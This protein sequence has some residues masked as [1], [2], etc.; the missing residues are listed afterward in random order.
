M[1]RFVP[2]QRK[3]KVLARQQAQAGP[4]LANAPPPQSNQEII[5][6][7]SKAERE[8]KKQKLREELRA[9]QP[10]ISSKKQKR[11]DK[12]IE[13][14]LRKDETLDLLRKLEQ[15]KEKYEAVV[16]KSSGNLG[17]RTFGDFLSDTGPKS[18]RQTQKIPQVQDDS[19]LDSEASFETEHKEAFDEEKRLEEP[20]IPHGPQRAQG[21]GLA[22]PLALDENGLPIIQSRRSNKRIRPR[23]EVLL[24]LP[25]E[26]FDS[27]PSINEQDSEGGDSDNEE[28]GSSSGTPNSSSDSEDASDGEDDTDTS[29]A[30]EEDDGDKIKPRNSAFKAW[31]TQQLNRS[32]GH[33][34]SY[35]PGEGQLLPVP[36]PATKSEAQSREPPAATLV[37]NPVPNRKAYAVHVSRPEDIQQARS[38]LP[39]LQ[40]EQEIMEAIHNNPVV[41]IKGDTGSGKTT[42]IPQF[43]F[44]AGY[45]SPD[46][47]TPGMIGITQPRRVAAVSMAKRVS[48]ELGEH[49]HKVAYQIRFDS[50]VS[51]N[52]AVKFMTD[53]IL[54]R[55]LS[56][57]LLL[58]KYSAIVVDEAH[59][60]S[61]NTDIL[62]GMLS[63]I[64]PAR[65]QKNQFNP[66]PTPLKLVIM[67][68]TLN[69]GDFL[70]EKL[71]SASLRPPIVEAEGRQHRVTTHF[72]LR[73]RAD[74]VEEVIEKVRRAHRKLPRGS[75]LV[76][77][78]GQNEIKQVGNRLNA[79][80]ARGNDSRGRTNAP[81]VEIAAC[82]A[83]LEVEDFELSAVKVDDEQDDFEMEILTHSEDEAEEKEFDISDDEDQEEDETTASQIRVHSKPMDPY[84]SVHILPLYSQL[85]TAE[86]LKVFEPPPPGARLIVLATNV[87]ETSLTIPGI[88][89]VFDTGRS[90][91]RKYNLD[92]GVQSFEIDYISKASAQ[93]RAGRAGRTGPGHCWR[94]YSSAVYEQFFPDHAEPEILRAPAESVVLQLKGFA[95][96]RPIAEFPFPTPPAAQTLNKAEQL[97]R[98]LGA[99]TSSGSITDLGRQLSMY[100]LSPRLGKILAASVA[101]PD[102][103]WQILALVSALAVPEIFVTE[104]QLNLNDDKT[105][106]AVRQQDNEDEEGEKGVYTIEKQQEDDRREK[107]RQEYGRARATLSKND[108][109]SDAMKLL[110]AVSLYLDSSSP[111]SREALCKSLFLRP[112]AMA[113]IAQ[114][115]DQLDHLV[116]MNHRNTITTETISKARKTTKVS[117]LSKVATKINTIVASG[118]IDQIAIRYDK[119]P[120][121]PS[122]IPIKPRR[123]IDV[124]YLPLVPLHESP[125]APLN[126]KAVFIHPSSVLARANIKDLP[127]Y[128]CYSHLQRSQTHTITSASSSSHAIPKTR[129]FPLTPVTAAQ[130]AY[131]A[132]DTALV[133]YGKPVPKTKI[134]EMPGSPRRRECW[135]TV[136]L[137]AS[138]GGALGWPLPPAKV[139]QVMDVKSKTGWR[140]EKVLT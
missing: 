115:R 1:P 139:R 75:I 29:E 97:L 78:T 83:P 50:N 27:E 84:T 48:T 9:Q 101:E 11:L 108:K 12:Y 110:T 28:E 72:A 2:R 117:S 14:K 66:N 6:P 8:A 112:K 7:Q 26:G 42:Q 130:L 79:L 60:R 20:P 24:E 37:P 98:N 31:A 13:N 22:Q 4:S 128:I 104:A 74:Y 19:D 35:T 131:I 124:P 86:Q 62:I 67:S 123:P 135:V 46:G 61:V 18:K 120:Q 136:E 100:P 36:K 17:K 140:V 106:A 57:D 95:Y 118:Y 73:S 3:H 58:R 25:W 121:P 64:V 41:I 30:H 39:I 69:I 21:S 16:A 10:H 119:A 43:L 126:E 51:S 125:S 49:G 102:L 47:P 113:E 54:L 23:D 56:E 34:P 90:K 122:D 59:E 92:T 15:E 5:V 52:T 93:Q 82:E 77:L 134:E 129:M 32:M 137:R 116:R 70:H 33:T 53:G 38:Q 91:E 127:E 76:F 44:E 107:L 114:L 111:A 88:R 105:T 138:V 103:L 71:F 133:N 96:P 65:M 55:E 45:G 94:L 40:R 80:L 85:P 109:T 68:A 87:A 89:Y 63:K 81:R 99:L 132:R